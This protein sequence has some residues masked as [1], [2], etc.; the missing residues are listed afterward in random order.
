[1]I[2]ITRKLFSLYSYYFFISIYRIYF[3][4]SRTRSF[5]LFG[6]NIFVYFTTFHL[7]TH[8][9]NP[10]CHF[11]ISSA[12]HSAQWRPESLLSCFNSPLTFCTRISISHELSLSFPPSLA[13]SFTVFK[14]LSVML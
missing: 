14:F 9:P 6:F 1:M 4:F 12:N 8:R 10:F 13:F 5:I 3:I 2:Y 11:L 7:S